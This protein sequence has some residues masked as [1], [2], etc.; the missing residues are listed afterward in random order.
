MNFSIILRVALK[1]LIHH[2]LRSLLTM[3]GIIIGVLAIVA[4]RSIGE[5]AKLKVAQQINNLGSNFVIVIAGSSKNRN[6]GSG[7]GAQGLLTLK[8]KEFD[9]ICFESDKIAYASPGIGTSASVLYENKN[10]KTTLIGT[11]ENYPTI[12][13]WPCSS[14]EYFEKHDVTTAQK[15]VIIGKTVAKELFENDD[16]V[17]KKIRLNNMPFTILGVLTEK[18]K[19]PDGRDEDDMIFA[20]WS[21]VQKKVMGL[22]DGFSVFI[23]SAEEKESTESLV[24]DIRLIMRQQHNIGVNDEDDFTI[25]SQDEIARASE[26]AQTALTLLLLL[27]ASIALLVGGIG[28]MNIMLVTVSERT[29]EIGIRMALGAKTSDI[30]TQFVL[31]AIIIC[32]IG[33]SIGIGFGIGTALL[34][35]YFLQWTI[36][37]ATSSIVIGLG[38]SVCIGLFFGYYP[39]LKASLL[40][41][42]DAL[43]E[44]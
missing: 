7:R 35:G 36:S 10:W 38:S 39:A 5:G 21:T 15:V 3:L 9:A 18:G 28:I 22:T 17:G 42:V 20:P 43:A 27:I 8:K 33:G 41:P 31:E 16:P 32:I 6:T 12:R 25:F 19:R 26:Q 30:L 34:V 37:I 11:N 23:F 1:S 24:Q 40:N 29:K 13:I 14:G 2:P 4:V 44:R